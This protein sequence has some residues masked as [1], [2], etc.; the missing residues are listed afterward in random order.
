[1]LLLSLILLKRLYCNIE[2]CF[3]SEVFTFVNMCQKEVL[4]E[5]RQ[6][7]KW[8]AIFQKRIFWVALFS[9]G[10]FQGEFNGWEFF[11]C[12]FR[13]TFSKSRYKFWWYI[14]SLDGKLNINIPSIPLEIILFSPHLKAWL[15]RCGSAFS[16]AP[17]FPNLDTI[18]DA[19]FLI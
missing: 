6:S 15:S 5:G 4:S 9:G 12:F 10:I 19:T 13:T 18:F 7:M 8:V 2:T 3:K 17:P 14:F 16:S 11:R 1:M